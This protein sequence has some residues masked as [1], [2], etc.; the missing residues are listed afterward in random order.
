MDY[1]ELKAI[2]EPVEVG[3]DVLIAKLA[4]INYESFV[5]TEQGVDAYIQ[6][7]DFSQNLINDLSTELSPNF[8]V[9]YKVKTIKDKNWNEVWEENFNPIVVDD[10]CSVRAPFHK[11]IENIVFDI[12][13]EPK[14][15]FGTGHHETTHLMIKQLLDLDLMNKDVLDMGCGTGVLAILAKMKNARNV[16]AIDIDEWAYNNTVENVKKNN[17]EDI[18]IEMGG[19]E[20]LI[21]EKFDV[22]IAN[23]NRNILLQDIKH[24][25]N[26]LK[27]KGILLLSGFFSSDK[28]LLIS[29]A[30]KYHLNLSASNTKNDWMILQLN[31]TGDA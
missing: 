31:K 20:L 23:I 5:D 19:A 28:A 16:V 29:E 14:M 6:K 11:K 7:Q 4:E 12:I 13:I 30:E 17:T 15:S 10:K 8:T 27:S 2:I 18:K 9:N 22:I 25:A 24:Y 26:V 21:D 3:R 1:I